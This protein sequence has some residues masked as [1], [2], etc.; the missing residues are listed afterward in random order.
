MQVVLLVPIG[1]VWK[2]I[3]LI[4]V[5]IS[6]WYLLTLKFEIQFWIEIER[7]TPCLLKLAQRTESTSAMSLSDINSICLYQSHGHLP[8]VCWA[9]AEMVEALKKKHLQVAKEPMESKGKKSEEAA[10]EKTEEDAELG[11]D[12]AEEEAAEDGGEEEEPVSDAVE[13]EKDVS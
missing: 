3:I 11:E 2:Q 7:A 13:D 1:K 5:S 6:R 4:D 9:K 10:A 8:D 12:P